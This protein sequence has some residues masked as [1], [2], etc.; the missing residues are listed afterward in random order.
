M[1]GG[2]RVRVTNA[3]MASKCQHV[4]DAVKIKKKWSDIKVEAKKHLALHRQSV[5]APGGGEGA[6]ELTPLE[7]K[8]AV[9][10]VEW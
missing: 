10:R 3:K 9:I 2:H 1:F 7:E 5:C 8:L 6:P 4:A